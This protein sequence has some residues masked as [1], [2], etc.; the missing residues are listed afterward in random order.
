M[1]GHDPGLA[2]FQHPCTRMSTPRT[3]AAPAPQAATPAAG[4]SRRRVVMVGNLFACSALFFFAACSDTGITAPGTVGALIASA[5]AA[6]PIPVAAPPSSEGVARA[7]ATPQWG[8]TTSIKGDTLIEA[9]TYT[10]AEGLVV[11]SARGHRIVMPERAI[12]NPATSGYGPGTW[13][14]RCTAATSSIRFTMRS[15]AARD[16]SAQITFAPD[17]RFVPD[18]TVLLQVVRPGG[19]S[20]EGTVGPIK[21]CTTAMTNCVDESLTDRALGTSFDPFVFSA[22]RR[23][24]HFSGF[25]TGFGRGGGTTN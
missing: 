9:F 13:D 5:A 7:V 11:T 24:K 20:A 16:G 18:K 2:P 10:P 1:R 6:R 17:V 19:A 21:W 8:L 15:W 22:W 4:A 14:K 25:T 23:V 12:C 3:I